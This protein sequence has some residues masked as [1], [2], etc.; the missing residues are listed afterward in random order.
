MRTSITVGVKV[1][2][3]TSQSLGAP[4]IGQRS[5]PPAPLNHLPER[6]LSRL[7]LSELRMKLLYLMLCLPEL[8]ALLI[9]LRFRLLLS[10]SVTSR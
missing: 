8:R 1:H 6:R 3:H 10:R 4:G 7:G 5:A 2:I 9:A